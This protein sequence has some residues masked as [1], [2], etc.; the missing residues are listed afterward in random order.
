M[1][2]KG[3]SLADLPTV[4]ISLVVAVIV[5]ALGL[6]ILSDT[7]DELPANSEEANAT[8]DG[9]EGIAKL[10]AKL[11]LIGTVVAAV[12]VIGLIVGAFAMRR[13]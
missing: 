5:I 4:A 6:S 10:S 11:P 13:K 9:I 7:K 8:A 2:K 1:S 3:V 12:L